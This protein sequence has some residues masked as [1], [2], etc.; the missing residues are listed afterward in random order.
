MRCRGVLSVIVNLP[1]MHI[2]P[3]YWFR[4]TLGTGFRTPIL[5]G[6]RHPG[7]DRQAPDRAGSGPHPPGR[8]LH[9][10]RSADQAFRIRR[11]QSGPGPARLPGHRVSGRIRG[12]PAAAGQQ[13]GTAKPVSLWAHRLPAETPSPRCPGEP[14]TSEHYVRAESRPVSAPDPR[15]TEAPAGKGQRLQLRLRPA[16]SPPGPRA[17]PKPPPPS[18]AMPCLQRA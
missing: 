3:W 1:E 12:G 14:A 5:G 2:P 9:R 10:N 13:Y 4:K 7:T 6:S 11:S 16:D 15:Q 17:G 8:D 18:G